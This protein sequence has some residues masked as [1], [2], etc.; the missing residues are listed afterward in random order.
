VPKR[1]KK[2]RS[3]GSKVSPKLPRPSR[4]QGS[5]PQPSL[6]VAGAPSDAN[7]QAANPADASEMPY[8]VGD[9]VSATITT[10]SSNGGLWLDVGGVVGIVWP[11]DLSLADGETTQ[12]RYALGDTVRGLFVWQIDRDERDL[13]LSVRRNTPGY[14]EALNA[15]SVGDVV[16]ATITAFQGNGGLWLDVD[17][18][19]GSVAPDEL[20]LADGESARDRYAVGNTVRDLFVWQVNHD[21]RYLSLSAR[22][23]AP[24]YVEALNAHSVGDVVSA[25]VAALSSDGGLWLDVGGVIGS[26]APDELSLADGESARDRYTD[27]DPA[28][29]LFVWQIDHDTRAL[30]LSVRRNAPGYVEALNAHSV[31][32]VVS[33][34]ITAFQGNGGLWLDVDGVIG[35]VAFDELSLAAGE[36]ARDRYIVGD[37]VDGL[38]VWQVDHDDRALRLSVRRNAPGYVEA[39]NAHSAGDIVSG[40]VTVLAGDGGLWLDAGGVIGSVGPQELSLADGETAQDRYIVGDPVDGLFVWQIDHDTREFRLSLRLNAPGYVEELNAYSVGDVVSATVTA[41]GGRGL[42]LDVDGT[43]GWVGPQELSLADGESVQDRYAVG[44]TVR[45]LFVWQVNHDERYLSLS[46]RRNAPGY[47]EALNAHSVGEVVSATVTAFGGT[48]LWLDVGGVAGYGEMSLHAQH[49]IGDEVRTFVVSID[50]RDRSLDT[51]VLPDMSDYSEVLSR[52]NIGEV[53]AGIVTDPDDDDGMFLDVEGLVGFVPSWELP[54]IDD[55]QSPGSRYATGDVVEAFLVGIAPEA[56]ALSLSVR[57]RNATYVDALANHSVGEPVVATVV[58]VAPDGLLLDV[59]GVSAGMLAAE[60]PLARG[61]SP[62]DRYTPGDTLNGF[63]VG[64]DDQSRALVLS[65]RRPGRAQQRARSRAPQRGVT[66]PRS[67]SRRSGGRRSSIGVQR[68]VRIAAP[69]RGD[70]VQGIVKRA[71]SSGVVLDVDGTFG[72]IP[73]FDLALSEGQ[74]PTDVYAIGDTITASV[75]NVL[76]SGALTLSVRHTAAAYGDTLEMYTAG[77]IVSGVV[78]WTHGEFLHIDVASVSGIVR[79]DEL[80]V[81]RDGSRAQRHH[82]GD[83]V[84]NLLVLRIDREA[85]RLVLSLRRTTEDYLASLAK[86]SVGDMVSGVITETDPHGIWLDVDGVIGRIAANE[87][88]LADDET[89]HG[90]CSIGDTVKAFLWQVYRTERRLELSIRRHGDGYAEALSAHSVDEVVSG[91]VTGTN[92]SGIWLLVGPLN[93]WIAAKELPLTAEE[94]PKDRYSDG[95]VVEARVWQIDVKARHLILSVQ[96]LAPE[97]MAKPIALREPIEVSVVQDTDSGITVLF[98]G[99]EIQIPNYI[100]SLSVGDRPIFEPRS[101]LSVVVMAMDDYGQPTVLSYRRSLEGWRK[102][103]DRF[104]PNMIVQDAEVIPWVAR[105]EGEARAM[106]DLGPI[107]GFVAETERD[108][109]AAEA[110]MKSQGNRKLPVVITALDKAVGIAEVSH[111]KFAARWAV[112]A[113]SVSVGQSRK[114]ELRRVTRDKAILDLGDGLQA[115][116]PREQIPTIEQAGERRRAREGDDFTVLITDKN[117]TEHVIEAGHPNQWL[118]NLIA[119]DENLT[120]EFKAVYCG[121]DR[122]KGRPKTAVGRGLPVLRAMAALMNQEGGYVLVGI[123]DT[124]KKEGVVIGWQSSKFL[125]KNNLKTHLGQNVRNHM[126]SP[127]AARFYDADFYVLPTGQEVLAIKCERA[128]VPIYLK[129]EP[130]DRY[131][132]PL[133][134]DA[135]TQVAWP[136]DKEE[137]MR[138]LRRHF[139]DRWPDEDPEMLWSDFQR[140][141]RTPPSKG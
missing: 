18:V 77:Q 33:A 48:G 79:P 35:S 117:E 129:N 130:K 65:T 122:F 55:D 73:P 66:S 46:V 42:W 21:E 120:C 61:Q 126:L 41:F 60:L 7:R 123:E 139:A 138:E 80:P 16:S 108:A 70:A 62:L 92:E 17:G 9:V 97:R 131:E 140:R 43:V 11:W 57:R 25:T 49:A 137:Q 28:D 15:R 72:I 134:R 107:T 58:L 136:L 22:R 4:G 45:D 40:T 76:D 69:Q 13:A 36:T 6:G 100:L 121:P 20:S 96:R 111:E 27:G 47:V 127:A 133:R 105:P 50:R 38:F 34:T 82:I 102:A 26:V 135:S 64:I 118:V 128:T 116:M 88:D 99:R 19:I 112:L 59:Q 52:H 53:V 31:G 90:K 67:A 39:L 94:S 2:R 98:K 74:A 104:V 106:L 30:R 44:N 124:D 23:N 51:L 37:P 71:L 3:S 84:D 56:A 114:A 75:T 89:P 87:L 141:V 101:S 125:N 115:E 81:A 63:V 132:F 83:A 86:H 110:L 68:G 29:A 85:R 8:S 24:G 93:A 119:G 12:D 109:E 95:D 103:V 54:P 14:V 5:A 1:R 32:D 78:T 91:T 10:I 113:A